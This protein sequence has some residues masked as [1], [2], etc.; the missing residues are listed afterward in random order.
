VTTN[1]NEILVF[2]FGVDGQMTLAQAFITTGFPPDNIFISPD[3][4]FI[5]GTRSSNG[6]IQRFSLVSETGL[7]SAMENTYSAVVN[8]SI[9]VFSKEGDYIFAKGFNVPLTTFSVDQNGDLTLV[10]SVTGSDGVGINLMINQPSGGG[11]DDDDECVPGSFSIQIKPPSSGTVPI[12][13][14]DN[15]PVAI[16]GRCD[17]DPMQDVVFTTARFENAEPQRARRGIKFENRDV[18]GDG[19]LD[20]I[21]FFPANQ[22]TLNRFS[23]SASLSIQA[24]DNQ[25]LTATQSVRILK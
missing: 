3:E 13:L 12:K 5:Y 17:F 7:I 16:M 25:T 15:I 2:S 8:T 21:L 10:S 19:Y 1:F 22:T 6:V 9:L 4:R 18:N 14:R 20:V 24:T 11:D 23:T